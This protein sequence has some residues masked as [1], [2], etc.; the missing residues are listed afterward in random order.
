MTC[1]LSKKM[2]SERMRD[3]PNGTQLVQERSPAGAG[4]LRVGASPMGLACRFKDRGES[5]V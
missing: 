1:F 3:L 4:V 2:S 5:G